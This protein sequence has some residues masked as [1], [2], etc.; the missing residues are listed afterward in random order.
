MLAT[1]YAL[2]QGNSGHRRRP[3]LIICGKQTTDGD[4]S[5]VGPAIAEHGYSPCGLGG[6]GVDADEH[7]ISGTGLSRYITGIETSISMSDNE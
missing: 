6:R 4:T 2:S 7:A 3:E 1:S 5:Q